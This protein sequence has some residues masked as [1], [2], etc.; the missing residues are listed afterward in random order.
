M[1]LEEDVKLKEAS[2]PWTPGHLQKAPEL[3]EDERKTEEVLK[4][5]RSILNKL[6]PEN[7]T[8]LVEEQVK[9]L[10]LEAPERQEPCIKMVFE[11]AIAEPKFATGYSLLCKAISTNTTKVEVSTSFKKQLITRCQKEFEKHRDDP[12]FKNNAERLSEIENEEDPVKKEELKIMYD[13]QSSNLRRRAAGTVQF[14]GELYKIEM[15]TS[16]IMVSCIQMLLNPELISEETLE[17]LCKLLTTIGKKLEKLDEKK[18]DLT[19][20][21]KHLTSIVS[22]KQLKISSRVRFMIQD[23]IDLRKNNWT[24]RRVENKPKTIDQIHKEAAFEQYSNQL[25]NSQMG[26]QRKTSKGP[27]DGFQNNNQNSNNNNQK[28]G[29]NAPGEDGWSISYS[30]N[31][32]PINFDMKK[33]NITVSSNF[34]SL[35]STL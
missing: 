34:S 29:G 2:N 16:K 27:R 6:T 32:R 22:K 13:E 14:I 5:F 12:A 25:L 20:T 30:K 8:K 9:K 18:H 31:S 24:P 11:K 26:H 33:V 35:L 19:E 7:F 4:K 17:S 1:K 3:T 23:L 15:L 10:D 28:R 21:F